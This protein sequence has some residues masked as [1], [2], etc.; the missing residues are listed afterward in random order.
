MNALNK[1]DIEYIEKSEEIVWRLATLVKENIETLEKVDQ[2]IQ[3]QLPHLRVKIEDTILMQMKTYQKVNQLFPRLDE[4]ESK[5]VTNQSNDLSL[6]GK[7]IKLYAPRIWNII[8]IVSKLKPSTSKDYWSNN[9]DT[10]LGMS[11]S[12]SYVS[13]TKKTVQ[14]NGNVDEQLSK[15]SPGEDRQ[16]I[17]DYVIKAKYNAPQQLTVSDVNVES[18]KGNTIK[19]GKMVEREPFTNE[20]LQIKQN[21][22]KTIGN[23]HVRGDTKYTDYLKSVGISGKIGQITILEPIRTSSNLVL[24]RD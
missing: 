23:L 12:A 6:S 9:L 17:E 4:L 11:L 7:S 19:I 8:N 3:H 18:K 16:L 2:L 21:E 13:K 22:S 15:S 14:A 10:N 1:Q 5:Y 24:I 20:V